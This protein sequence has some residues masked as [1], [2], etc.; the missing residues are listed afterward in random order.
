MSDI[1]ELQ[2]VRD[3]EKVAAERG[4]KEGSPVIGE[5]LRKNAREAA[6]TT[7]SVKSAPPLNKGRAEQGRGRDLHRCDHHK[8]GSCRRRGTRHVRRRMCLQI[9]TS[10]STSC[11]MNS[12]NLAVAGSGRERATRRD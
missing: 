1:P 10:W 3:A 2:K 6:R 12:Q 7:G 11:A 9:I 4:E 5:P 8:Q